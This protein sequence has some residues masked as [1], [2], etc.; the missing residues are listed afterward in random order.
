[1]VQ[2]LGEI[3]DILGEDKAPLVEALSSFVCAYQDEESLDV[4]HFLKTEAIRKEEHGFTTESV[5][6]GTSGIN[7][8][9]V[10]G[11]SD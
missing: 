7:G 6:S 8:C 1:M 4:E 9:I 3:L 5:S 11:D 10:T 2:A